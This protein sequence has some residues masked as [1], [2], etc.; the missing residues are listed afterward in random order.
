[1][2][3]G[4]GGLNVA[5][6]LLFSLQL[7]RKLQEKLDDLIV[8][9]SVDTF[10]SAIGRALVV[11]FPSRIVEIDLLFGGRSG[12][13]VLTAKVKSSDGL[14]TRVETNCVVKVDKDENLIEEEANTE[15]I[16]PHLGE[17]A[18]KVLCGG[19]HYE[20]LPTAVSLGRCDCFAF[21]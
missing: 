14:R 12:S 5:G 17:N 9:G 3:E 10:G 19:A 21:L 1:M 11:M 8:E 18:P 20:G 2:G 6:A 15:K 13:L 16:L 4:S 7:T